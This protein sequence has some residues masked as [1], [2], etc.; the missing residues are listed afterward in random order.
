MKYRVDVR[1]C[2]VWKRV[3]WHFNERFLYEKGGN[4]ELSL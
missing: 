4:H 1:D 2:W 3:R